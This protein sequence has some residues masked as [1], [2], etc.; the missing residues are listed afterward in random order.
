MDIIKIIYIIS[1]SVCGLIALILGSIFISKY[2]TSSKDW[3]KLSPLFL[4]FLFFLSVALILF[5][6]IVILP[7]IGLQNTI[8]FILIPS[9]TITFFACLSLV[10]EIRYFFVFIMRTVV[11]LLGIGG[12]ICLMIIVFTALVV[13]VTISVLRLTIYLFYFAM[14]GGNERKEDKYDYKFNSLIK[15]SLIIKIY[16]IVFFKGI[17]FLIKNM[18]IPIDWIFNTAGTKKCVNNLTKVFDKFKN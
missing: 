14:F 16:R 8:K 2:R 9:L 4:S 11:A 13:E 12:I 6:K 7:L 18:V 5:V 10:K 3:N 17:I 1:L 15:N